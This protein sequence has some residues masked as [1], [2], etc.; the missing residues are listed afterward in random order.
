MQ[1]NEVQERARGEE[2][3]KLER[4]GEWKAIAK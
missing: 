2:M 4:A 3:C 1:C